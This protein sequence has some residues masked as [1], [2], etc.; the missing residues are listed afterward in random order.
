MKSIIS[1]SSG[2][3]PILLVLST[4]LGLAVSSPTKNN[5]KQHNR[6]KSGERIQPVIDAA[7]P[8]DRII[9]EAG[10]YAE[11][12][13]IKK[14]GITLVGKNAIIVPPSDPVHNDCSGIAGS[15]PEGVVRQAGICIFGKDVDLEPYASEHQKVKS[16]GRYV[17]DVTVTGFEVHDFGLDIAIVGAKNAHAYKNTLV[18]GDQYGLLTAGSKNSFVNKNTITSTKLGF[19]GICADDVYGVEVTE[20][21]IS[22]VGIGLCIQTNGADIS[23][24]KVTETCVGA[25]VDPYVKNAKV[26]DNKITNT[27]PLC[28]PYFGAFIHGIAV[29]GAVDTVVRDNFIKGITD[30]GTPN[31]TVGGI[32]L[33]DDPTKNPPAITSGTKVKHNTLKN[34]DLDIYVATT[35][36]DNIFK[37]NSCSTR[38]CGL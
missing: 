15:T 13:L 35:G 23:S 17:K 34:N 38:N 27:G 4:V 36:S 18:N 37:D 16:V 33:F 20:N 29:L 6:V 32:A 30:S 11:Q 25:F 5:D 19:I 22:G 28:V 10:T 2:A 9:V 14:D 8:G 3:A 1:F 7:K 21:T 24:N 31:N 12:L 26:S